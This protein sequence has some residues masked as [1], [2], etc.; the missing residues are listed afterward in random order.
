MQTYEWERNCCWLLEVRIQNYTFFIVVI[1][2]YF[3]YAQGGGNTH[4][5]MHVQLQAAMLLSTGY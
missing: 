2:T 4:T 3:V 5:H 1:Q